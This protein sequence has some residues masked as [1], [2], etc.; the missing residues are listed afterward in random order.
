MITCYWS[1]CIVMNYSL[2]ISPNIWSVKIKKV[3]L[4]F[5]LKERSALN[6]CL[7]LNGILMNLWCY[8]ESRSWH[9]RRSIGR[10]GQWHSCFDVWN[11]G[12]ILKDMILINVSFILNAQIFTMMQTKALISVVNRQLLDLQQRIFKMDVNTD[13]I[14]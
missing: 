10:C 6:M 4:S 5:D 7:T 8:Y 1:V 12:F 14:K 13:L 3:L 11:V 9:G 2:K